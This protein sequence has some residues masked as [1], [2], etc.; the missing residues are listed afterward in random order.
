MFCEILF[1][2]KS[3]VVVFSRVDYVSCSFMC[4][5]VLL[6]QNIQSNGE[7]Y[8]DIYVWILWGLSPNSQLDNTLSCSPQTPRSQL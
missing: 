2:D 8:E 5:H 1:L 3:P 7:V 6:P 4:L